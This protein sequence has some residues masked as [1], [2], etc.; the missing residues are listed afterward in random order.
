MARPAG[1][2][3]NPVAADVA[4]PTQQRGKVM[5]IV[6]VLVPLFGVE[7]DARALSAAYAIA[8]KLNASVEALFVHR[9]PRETVLNVGEGASQN[10]IDQLRRAVEAGDLRRR[11]ARREF[12]AAQPAASGGAEGGLVASTWRE[13][14]DQDEQPGIALVRAARFADLIVLPGPRGQSV[15]ETLLLES[16]RPLLLAPATLPPSIGANIAIAWSNTSAAIRAVCGAMPLL[17]AAKGIHVIT[18]GIDGASE[19]VGYLQRHGLE[20]TAD[21]AP[22][23][24]P[25]GKV[26]LSKARQLEADFLVMGG[27]GHSRFR[28]LVLGGVTRHVVA[29]ADLP[30]IMAH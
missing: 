29:H 21:S 13:L 4:L 8:R 9:D 17:R 16:G 15:L 2:G 26:L 22:A 30:V 20:A 23:D 18:V 3:D 7:G 11:L 6:V 19:L 27:Y 25:V 5:D 28:E 24:G 12:E 14:R 1:F 10:I